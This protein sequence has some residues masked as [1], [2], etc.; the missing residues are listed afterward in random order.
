MT[1]RH[2]HTALETPSPA[3]LE[4][5]TRI[6]GPAHALADPDQQLPFLREWRDVYFGRAALVLRPG[7]VGEVAAIMAA[8]NRA[9]VGVVPQSG[10]TG[11]VGGQIP[12]GSGHQIVLSTM[13]LDR[14]RV[15]DA[16]TMTL[17]AEAGVTLAEA[18]AA[19]ERAGLL[20]PLSLPSEGSCRIGGNLATNA[21]GVGVLAYGN[22]R[23]LVLGIEAVLADGQV[24]HGLS[25]LK[26][27]NAGY[28]IKDL[29][30]GSEGTLA[31]IT[32]ATLKLFPR[33]AARTTALAALTGI[34]DALAILGSAQT[35][36]G[37]KLTAF[38]F[39]PRLALE[40]VCRHVKG[41]RDPFPTAHPWYVLL[42]ISS[43]RDDGSSEREMEAIL[44]DASERG[45]V[46][47]ATIATSLAQS[48][49]LWRL[50][51]GISEAQKPEGG[52]IKH[53][54]SVPIARIPEFIARANAI[55]ERLAPGARPLPLGHFGDGNVHYNIAQPIGGDKAAFLA[56]WEPISAEIHALVVAMEG[57]IAAEHGVGQMKRQA[58]A[59]FKAGTRIEVMRRVKAALD[60]AGILNPGKVV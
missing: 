30:I 46:V 58:L 6:V 56:L 20:Y 55:V 37:G 44:S 34:D 25:T 2:A 5:L 48:R 17:V 4:E 9:R 50:R 41:A 60:P 42:E 12:D 33:P 7:S 47:D 49:D 40:F 16:G 32:A 14:I 59:A 1:D 21:G 54:V 18:Q 36:V 11:L 43:P 26:K 23:S 10:N 15:V 31:V 45:M 52:N 19:A 53:D 8:C 27:D 51:E 13:R 38:E 28:D 57:S 39:I 3:L 24:W 35:A 22:T 29:L